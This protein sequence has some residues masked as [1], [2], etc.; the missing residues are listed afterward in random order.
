MFRKEG[1][2]DM[3]PDMDPELFGVFIEAAHDFKDSF[4][5]K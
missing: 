4:F 2:Q 5:T 1:E 3:D